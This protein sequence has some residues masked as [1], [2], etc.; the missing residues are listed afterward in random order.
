MR[1]STTAAIK[2]EIANRTRTKASRNSHTASSPTGNS[3]M[4]SLP[5]GSNRTASNPMRNSRTA[6]HKPRLN[7]D[8]TANNSSMEVTHSSSSRMV[9]S[10]DTISDTV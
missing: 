2:V 6:N 9:N 5:T 10:R 3:L 8:R 1:N 7:S 4:V